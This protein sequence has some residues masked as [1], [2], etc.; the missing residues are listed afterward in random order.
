MHLVSYAT[1]DALER[2]FDVST[3]CLQPA[4]PQAWCM[5]AW[6]Y[7]PWVQK[8]VDKRLAKL[9]DVAPPTIGFHVRGGDKLAE[10][11]ML[12]CSTSAHLSAM[13]TGMLTGMLCSRYGG[14]EAY[15]QQLPG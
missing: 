2:I 10:D 5:Q 14:T 8:A 13:L 12:V 1:L 7:Q 15:H 6:K 9:A 3:A 11:K 4:H